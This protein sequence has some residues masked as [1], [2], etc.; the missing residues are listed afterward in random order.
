MGPVLWRDH[1]ILAID[2]NEISKSLG[3]SIDGLLGMDLLRDFAI[4]IVDLR[5]YKLILKDGGVNL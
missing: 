3:E 1:Q 4:V 5:Q 2:T